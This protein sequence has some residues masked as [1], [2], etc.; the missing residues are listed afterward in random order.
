[1][2]RNWDLIRHILLMADGRSLELVKAALSDFGYTESAVDFHL[3]ILGSGEGDAGFIKTEC[4]LVGG[5]SVFHIDMLMRLGITKEVVL[6]RTWKGEEFKELI[7]RAEVWKNIKAICRAQ[8][9]PL[10][11]IAITLA[12]SNAV[13][14][15]NKDFYRRWHD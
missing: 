2:K 15:V 10:S 1:M 13:T 6:R 7:A 4:N 8:G 3:A 12:Y 5:E 11:E 9:T 14:E